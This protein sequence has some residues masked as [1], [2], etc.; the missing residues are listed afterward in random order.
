M[1][2]SVVRKYEFVATALVSV[3]A[4]IMVQAHEGWVEH[5]WWVVSVVFSA[6]TGYLWE[7]YHD[8]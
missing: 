7:K 1:K 3:F 5:A 6:T 2:K 8:R 4:Y